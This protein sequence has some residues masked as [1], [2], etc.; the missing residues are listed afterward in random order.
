MNSF[1]KIFHAC[2][3]APE[4]QMSIYQMLVS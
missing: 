1:P 4:I 2:Y 3:N